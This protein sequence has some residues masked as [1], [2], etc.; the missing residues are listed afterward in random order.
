MNMSLFQTNAIFIENEN[1]QFVSQQFLHLSLTVLTLRSDGYV[2][3]KFNQNAV[4]VMERKS[5][6]MKKKRPK[7]KVTFSDIESSDDEISKLSVKNSFSGDGKS[8]CQNVATSTLDA[9]KEAISYEE[10][11]Q[12]KS[13]AYSKPIVCFSGVYTP[14]PESTTERGKPREIASRKAS[15]RKPKSIVTFSDVDS[16][17][18]EIPDSDSRSNGTSHTLS[19]VQ[20]DEKQ[21]D[22]L[23]KTVD[24]RVSEETG[25]GEKYDSAKSDLPKS[26]RDASDEEA[27]AWTRRRVQ[28]VVSS[29]EDEA[30][31]GTRRR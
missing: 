11:S 6:T 10:K 26:E 21:S 1:F 28:K 20:K 9:D 29:S 23:S 12:K 31:R 17:E 7:T 15:T 27:V 5:K 24:Y 16:S 25:Q 30:S 14:S 8:A 4:F 22:A 19:F 18:E 2:I 13:S 3:I